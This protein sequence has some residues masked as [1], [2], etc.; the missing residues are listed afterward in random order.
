MARPA[1]RSRGRARRRPADRRPRPGPAGAF[2]RCCRPTRRSGSGRV[3]VV[4]LHR[5]HDP[6]LCERGMSARRSL[7][8]LDAG[9]RRS[10]A[11]FAAAAARTRRGPSVPASPIAWISTCQPRRSASATMRRGCLLPIPAARST[12]VVVR[13]EHRRGSRFDDAVGEGL[14]DAGVS[15]CAAAQVADERIVPVEP[16]VPS[17]R[18]IPSGIGSATGAHLQAPVAAEIPPEA[19]SSAR[20]RRPGRR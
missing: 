4:W 8:V 10:R 12:V 14:E 20:P 15:H 18:A 2:G 9:R 19:T 7:D 1:S 17:P 6:E 3:G 16:S 5:G 13:I 11:G